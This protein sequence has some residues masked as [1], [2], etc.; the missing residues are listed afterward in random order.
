[1]IFNVKYMNYLINLIKCLCMQ[2][3]RNKFTINI[4]NLSVVEHIACVQLDLN[5]AYHC[6][7]ANIG[8]PLI[9]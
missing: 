4:I 2:E 5:F 9:K 8:Q 6:R 3:K 1:M 7:I